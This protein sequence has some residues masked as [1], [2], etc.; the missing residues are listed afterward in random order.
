MKSLAP[1]LQQTDRTCVLYRGRRFSYFGGCDYYR[2]SSH[3]TIIAALVAGLKKYGLTTAASRKTTGNHFLYGQLEKRLAGFFGTADAVLVSNGYATNLVVAQA[4]AG[5]FSHV[6]ID[7]K[8]HASLVDA[9][10]FFDGP[11][12]NF[13]HRDTSAVRRIMERIG[14]QSRP[15]LLTDGMFSHDGGLA[16]ID[17][18]LRSLPR[19]AAI[20]L[21]DAHGAGILGKTGKGTAEQLGVRSD[22]IVQ[23]ISLGKAFGVY[24]GAVLG[25]RS[26]CDR[27]RDRSRLFGGN[28]PPPLPLVNAALQA[29]RILGSDRSLPR[30]LQ[31]NVQILRSELQQTDFLVPDTP[32]PIMAVVPQT[33]AQA[34]RLTKQLVGQR[35]YPSFIRYPG[36][37]DAGYFRFAIS[38]EH[39]ARQIISLARALTGVGTAGTK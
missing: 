22:R 17:G 35:V 20:L 30:R 5:G 19:N 29:V 23:T 11:I 9:T 6:L 12:I 32:G 3:P 37:A 27:I 28:T 38:S 15:V 39:S 34:R 36:G 14:R 18:Y 25:A 8:A 1:P 24:G 13:S 10:V 16:P 2:L 7:E 26:V 21:D 4:L 31:Q 33:P